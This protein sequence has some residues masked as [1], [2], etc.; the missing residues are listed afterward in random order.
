MDTHAK[1]DHLDVLNLLNFVPCP[2]VSPLDCF[3]LEPD[4]SSTYH[5]SDESDG[6]EEESVYADS[7]FG[8][9]EQVD[10]PTYL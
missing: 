2:K 10:L 3:P 4:F 9:C 8:D 5:L 7:E 1:S 6:G